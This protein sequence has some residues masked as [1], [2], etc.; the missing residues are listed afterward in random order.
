M[1]KVLIVDD[2][3]VA[4]RL[5]AKVFQQV[6]PERFE[7]MEAENG[8]VALEKVKSDHPD[9]ILCDLTMPEMSG[10]EFCKALRS[11]GIST[12]L[13]IITSNVTEA[14]RDE[15]MQAGAT[16][17]FTKPFK[18]DDLK[19]ALEQEVSGMREEFAEDPVCVSETPLFS[20][21]QKI[22]DWMKDGIVQFCTSYP[23]LKMDSAGPLEVYNIKDIVCGTIISIEHEGEARALGVFGDELSARHVAYE[24]LSLTDAAS[25]TKEDIKDAFGEMANMIVANFLKNG[26]HYLA[27]KQVENRTISV[28]VPEFIMGWTCAELFRKVDTKHSLRFV[29]NNLD[30]KLIFVANPKDE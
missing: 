5:T 7:L 6:A 23:T 29:G 15:L 10:L 25:A 17:F 24:L 27:E 20:D 26:E 4:R 3:K 8:R 13:G 2:S 22:M 21:I 30:I 9:L 28:G 11:E 12:P 19:K 18:P 16:F 14:A 1:R